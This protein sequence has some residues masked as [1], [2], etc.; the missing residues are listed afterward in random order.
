MRSLRFAIKFSY[1]LYFFTE[2]YFLLGG[3]MEDDFPSIKDFS[4]QP[5]NNWKN[6]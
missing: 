6:F 3:R 2:W 5:T 4:K 1:V